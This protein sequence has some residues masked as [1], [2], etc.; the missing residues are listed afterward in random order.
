MPT[1]INVSKEL[2]EARAMMIKNH[3]LIIGS[4]EEI[5]AYVDNLQTVPELQH[6]I[7]VL[8]KAVALLVQDKL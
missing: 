5:N 4:P 3:P 7:K 2:T 1:K 8:A 6:A